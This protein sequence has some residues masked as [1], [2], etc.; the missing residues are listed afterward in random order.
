MYHNELL[1]LPP[2]APQVNPL[3]FLRTVSTIRRFA[4]VHRADL[5]HANNLLPSQAAF[6][7][8]RSLGVPI[9]AHVR[10]DR[11]HRGSRYASLVRWCDA[12]VCI[13]RAVSRNYW[14]AKLGSRLKVI[15][16]GID[17]EAF[18]QARPLRPKGAS[19]SDGTPVVGT[20][21]FLR[22]EKGIDDFIRVAALAKAA[23]ARCRFVIAGE[24]PNRAELTAL[25]RSLRVQDTVTFLGYV[26]DIASFMKSLD[27]FLSTSYAEGFG[28]AVVEASS[29][30]LPVVAFAVGGIPEVVD[31]GR[32]GFLVPPGHVNRMWE[33]VR[34]LLKNHELRRDLGSAGHRKAR[35]C[36]SLQAYADRVAEVYE[37]LL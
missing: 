20:A 33:K 12:V 35:T 14:P 34:S 18:A 36:F 5:I 4:R 23:G 27:V 26:P 31:D 30:G 17:V 16:N 32:T 6:V 21:A 8:A 10:S 11:Y 22:P 19:G 2:D 9:V 29:A 24:G 25:A 13:S 3:P 15:Y 37:S 28:R 1:L 7:A